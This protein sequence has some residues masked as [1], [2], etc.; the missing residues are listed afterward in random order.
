MRPDQG[1]QELGVSNSVLRSSSVEGTAFCPRKPQSST[2]SKVAEKA[3]AQEV[4]AHT[5]GPGML[6]A[7]KDGWD[8]A[9]VS[10][11]QL[12]LGR[13][14]VPTPELPGNRTLAW[15]RRLGAGCPTNSNSPAGCLLL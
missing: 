7:Q 1:S 3:R 8:P 2:L 10:G 12:S 14:H 15:E 5:G 9:S 13:P 11:P 4:T 6:G